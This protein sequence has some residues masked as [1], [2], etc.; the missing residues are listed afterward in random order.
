MLRPLTP[1]GCGVPCWKRSFPG[2]QGL[3]LLTDTCKFAMLVS[4]DTSTWI[5]DKFSP[6]SDV[7]RS[8]CYFSFPL[9]FNHIPSK[10]KVTTESSWANFLLM[11]YTKKGSFWKA[12][13][14]GHTCAP[15][16]FP[17]LC[18]DDTSASS[19]PLPFPGGVNRKANK[20]AETKKITLDHSLYC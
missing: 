6:K 20:Q 4:S 18:P 12:L 9:L 3:S 13:T 16:H 1:S 7:W 8:H 19:S 15:P 17:P 11:F 10:T 5:S 14:L 2:Q